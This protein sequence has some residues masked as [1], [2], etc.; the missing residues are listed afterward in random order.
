MRLKSHARPRL[1]VDFLFLYV[2]CC[3]R[4]KLKAPNTNFYEEDRDS[5]EEVM[6]C[7][8]NVLCYFVLNCYNFCFLKTSLVID[9]G[10]KGLQLVRFSTE[11]VV[12]ES[13]VCFR[14]YV[15]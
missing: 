14:R 11:S 3:Y 6:G 4:F 10:R 5:E 9:I 8:L 13:G 12:R 7:L 15:T 2:V 1:V